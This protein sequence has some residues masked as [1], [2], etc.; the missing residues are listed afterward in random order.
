MKKLLL[1]FLLVFFVNA[2]NVTVTNIEQ[3]TS[4]EQGEFSHP[5]VGPKGQLLFS[6]VGFVGLYHL[7]INGK[8]KTISDAPGAGYEPTFSGDGKYVYYRPYKYEG[9]KK[10]SSLIK[11]AI[12]GTNEK[13]LIQ[14]ERDFTSA[15]RLLNG[16]IAVSRNF[17]LYDADP[18]QNQTQKTDLAI[19]VFIEKGKI[20]LY[21][22]GEKKILMPLGEGFYLWPS[23][24]P[25][26]SK[27]LFTKTGEG[28]YISNLGGQIL[29]ELGYANAPRWSPD[30]KWVVFMHDLDD[31]HQM[32]E[33]DIFIIAADGT[34]KTAITHTADIIEVY[35]FWGV[36]N[37]IVFGSEKGIIYKALLDYK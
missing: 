9:M 34:K 2:Q 28:T 3:V 20:A 35:P 10:L 26:G 6:G 31:G 29:A 7:D 23:I 4:L 21:R 37:E 36:E 24:S 5:V 30:G 18:L 13:I 27:L 14:D 32:I 22:N 17:N 15:K 1:L 16:N 8:I 19:G 12:S 11:K 33:S 25:D